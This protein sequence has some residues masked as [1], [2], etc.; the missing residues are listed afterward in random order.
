MTITSVTNKLIDSKDTTKNPFPLKI[1]EIILGLLIRGPSCGAL[2]GLECG[3]TVSKLYA[4]FLQRDD[5]F[6]GIRTSG[7][8]RDFVEERGEDGCGIKWYSSGWGGI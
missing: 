7:R 2:E 4:L 6:R 3:E 1:H 8:W 5:G